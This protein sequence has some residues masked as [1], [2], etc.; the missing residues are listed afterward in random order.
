MAAHKYI[1]T[2]CAEQ[3]KAFMACKAANQN[4]EACLSKAAAVTGCVVDLCAHAAHA[5]GAREGEGGVPGAGVSLAPSGGSGVGEAQA[6]VHTHRR[7]A[8]RAAAAERRPCTLARRLK[9]LNGRCGVQLDKY[10]ACLDWNGRV[11]A[12]PAHPDG[13]HAHASILRASMTHAARERRA[14]RTSLGRREVRRA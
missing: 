14:R 1:G 12:A 4:P 10:A 7:P 13:P 2:K 11:P 9:G 8:G 5:A 6:G 3:S